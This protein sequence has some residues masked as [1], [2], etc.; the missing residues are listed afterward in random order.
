MPTVTKA[1]ILL[2]PRASTLA[3]RAGQLVEE[4]LVERGIEAAIRAN[5]PVAIEQ[6]VESSIDATLIEQLRIRLRERLHGGPRYER[7]K[8][9]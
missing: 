8:T 6:H 3:F 9:A 7:R 5:T 4:I 2:D 1:P